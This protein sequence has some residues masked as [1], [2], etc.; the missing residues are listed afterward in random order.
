MPP[1]FPFYWQVKDEGGNSN[2]FFRLG[3]KSTDSTQAITPSSRGEG[4]RAEYGPINLMKE[5]R[6]GSDLILLDE[7]KSEGQER[8]LCH[9][10][11]EMSNQLTVNPE[12][13]WLA[14]P[15]T[16][17]TAY[18]CPPTA[19]F[20]LKEADSPALLTR[21]KKVNPC[22]N[23]LQ[24][25]KD[26]V[27]RSVFIRIYYTGAKPGF[28]IAPPSISNS[29]ILSLILDDLS[30]SIVGLEV[31][32]AKSMNKEKPRYSNHIT[33]IKPKTTKLRP[34]I[35]ADTETLLDEKSNAHVPDAVGYMLVSPGD[36]FYLHSRLLERAANRSG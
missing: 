7:G 25:Y 6:L 19:T 17:R 33:A 3:L 10:V 14:R 15:L 30:S 2:Q 34:F 12:T 36:V 16:L 23:R 5:P 31:P 28:D 18:T 27:I 13:F 9:V 11:L 26:S 32:E 20:N 29:D 24:K 22:T 8:I 21:F 35:V 4:N 1:Y